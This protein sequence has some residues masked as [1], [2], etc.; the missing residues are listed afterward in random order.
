VDDPPATD[1]SRAITAIV[2]E[3][4]SRR[5]LIADELRFLVTNRIPRRLATQFFGWFSQ[6]R[7]PLVRDA[8]IW[9]WTRLADLEL[10]EAKKTGFDSVHDCFVRELRPGCRTIDPCVDVLV[11]PCDG[12]VG[13]CGDIEGTTVFQ[14]KGFPYSLHD[15]LCDADLV[16][17]YRDGRYVT[18]RLTPSMYHRFHSPADCHVSG[19]TYISGDTWNVDPVAVQRIE[20]LYCRNERVVIDTCL[21]DSKERLTLVPVAAILVASIRLNFLDVTLNLTYRGPNRIACDATF[22]KGDE[23]GYFHH[24]STIVVFAT[25]GLELCGGVTSGAK[26]RMGQPLFRYSRPQRDEN[27]VFG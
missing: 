4:P 6:I 12:I 17:R 25:G 7:Q 19:V 2:R 22:R 27:T 26:L 15:L 5:R 13:A 23:I 10:H 18:L 1:A 11:S 14:A 3:F 21:H 24:G 20:R 16:E 8:S 9:L